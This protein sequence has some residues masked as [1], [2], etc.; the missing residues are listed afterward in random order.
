[1]KMLSLDDPRW[2]T[3]SGGYRIPYNPTPALR[4]LESG[5]DVWDALW[6]D[7]HHQGDIGDAS[8]AAVPHIVRIG[9]A[10]PKRDWNFYGLVSVIETERHRKTNPQ[11]LD[12]LA[13]SNQSER[14]EMQELAS[15]DLK[16]VNDQETIKSILGTLALAKGELQLGALLIYSDP[17]KIAEILDQ[18]QAWSELY[19]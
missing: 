4:R 2:E 7:L 3:L 19:N 13:E 5:E 6:E 10:L 12:W 16:V 18:Y 15:Q 11:P 9:K 8:Y 17:S 14:Q 1:M